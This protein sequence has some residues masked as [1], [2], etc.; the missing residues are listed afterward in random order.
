MGKKSRKQ[1]TKKPAE[2]KK[3]KD[4]TLQRHFIGMMMGQTYFIQNKYKPPLSGVPKWSYVSYSLC[5]DRLA[6]RLEE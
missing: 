1:K 4:E 6:E 5:G 2:L 3:A